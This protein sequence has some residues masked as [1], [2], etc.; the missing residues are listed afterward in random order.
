MGWL[1]RLLL[2]DG[3]G[4]KGLRKAI[5]ACLAT[6]LSL[7][8]PFTITVQAFTEL[9]KPFAGGEVDWNRMWLLLGIGVTAFVL[10]FIL[11]KNEYRK[12][13]GNAYGQAEETRL[14]VAEHMRTL[15]MSF[16]N[17]RD[18]SELSSNI[19]SDCTNVEQTLSSAIPQLAANVVSI[20]IVCV[21]LAF[22]D[23][24][25]ALAVFVTLPLAF[26]VFWLSR[27][28]QSRA[29]S[30]QV[31]AKVNAEKQ[32]Q[33]YL[34]GIKV[35]RACG[36]G[37]ERFKALDDAF[38]ELKRASLQVE[39]VS[40]SAMAVS[41]MLLRAGVGVTAFVGVALLTGGQI[42]FLTML[43]FLLIVVRIYGPILTVLTLLPDLLYLSIS[44]RRLHTLIDTE[45]MKGSTDAVPTAFDVVFE[46]V[47]FSYNQDAVL[48][49]VSFRAPAGKITALV[50]PSGS[51]KSTL[52]KL[53][54]RFWDAQRGTVRIGG[55]DVKEVD[56]E[57]LMK[58]IAFVFQDVTLFNDTIENNIRVGNAQAT[59]EEVRAAARA[60][61]CDEFVS[62]LPEGYQTLLGE[63]GGTL[64]GGERQR[65]SIAR[66]L[67]KDAPIVLLDEATAS[68]DP[69]SELLV[70]NAISR[71]VAG[72]TTIV[73]AHRLRTITQA[74]HIVVLEDGVVVEQ[75]THEELIENDGLYNRLCKIQKANTAWVR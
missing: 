26:L 59:D 1:E 23:W 62:A 29:F 51:G 5:V 60:A 33:E 63:N 66:A 68:L 21:A 13:Y 9:M 24:R 70:Q 64:S 54:A 4:K 37:G 58:R 17:T 48:E 6:S 15:P 74:D 39:L 43:M 50:G 14:R 47:S 73:I 75:G 28:L 53:A 40:G 35:I 10:T 55:A 7:M 18:L 27:A 19:M 25:M 61:Q 2:L 57:E 22:F 3:P 16:F 44:S 52:A 71:L 69:E 56:P 31:E 42:D 49:D 12:S 67:L 20:L 38:L 45:P 41:S 8:I 11:S 30:R 32:S 46:G 65:I 72:K 34:E 36:L